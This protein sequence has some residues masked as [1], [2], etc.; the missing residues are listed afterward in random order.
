MYTQTQTAP[1]TLGLPE[2]PPI[3]HLLESLDVT[4]HGFS[5][6]AIHLLALRWDLFLVPLGDRPWHSRDPVLR[7]SFGPW[8][9][10]LWPPASWAF[11]N[12]LN[13]PSHRASLY[14]PWARTLVIVKLNCFW[15]SSS[16]ARS[17]LHMS[18]T[19]N[20]A[21]PCSNPASRR[22]HTLFES[23]GVLLPLSWES[24]G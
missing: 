15:S 11:R 23:C 18:L 22:F 17:T 20:R 7:C 13:R 2:A 21:D 12:A 19:L 10:S 14:L 9:D 16:S 8:V 4:L 1:S 6:L 24:P 3:Q 5:C